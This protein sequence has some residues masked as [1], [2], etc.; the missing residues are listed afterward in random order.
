MSLEYNLFDPK[1]KLIGS[2]PSGLP[3]ETEARL[4]TTVSRHNL[5]PSLAPY[6]VK[7][8][9]SLSLLDTLRSHCLLTVIFANL[10]PAR[11]LGF[12]SPPTPQQCKTHLPAM[13]ELFQSKYNQLLCPAGEPVTLDK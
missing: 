1:G 7:L 3:S 9:T 12:S 8:L 6:P 11:Y 5:L 4:K 2:L 10:C 13:H